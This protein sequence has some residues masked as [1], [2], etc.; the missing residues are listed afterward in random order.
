MKSIAV[1][2]MRTIAAIIPKSETQI[3]MIW[4]VQARECFTIEPLLQKLRSKSKVENWSLNP[5]CKLTGVKSC[6]KLRLS[7]TTDSGLNKTKVS[8]P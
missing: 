2:T 1:I 4:K 6:R 8:R 7:G 3:A 5:L